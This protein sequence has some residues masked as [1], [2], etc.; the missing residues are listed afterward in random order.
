MHLVQLFNYSISLYNGLYLSYFACF[1][2]PFTNVGHI[3]FLNSVT[4][5]Q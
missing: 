3:L 2:R 5:W 1:C 4:D